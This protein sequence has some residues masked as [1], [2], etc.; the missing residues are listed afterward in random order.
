MNVA[1]FLGSKSAAESKTVDEAGKLT[2]NSK[3]SVFFASPASNY[4]I[5]GFDNFRLLQTERENK[6][7]ANEKNIGMFKQNI[8]FFL[9]LMHLIYC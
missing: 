9:N 2:A 7:E 3:L 4:N 1:G 5:N 8:Q 6:D